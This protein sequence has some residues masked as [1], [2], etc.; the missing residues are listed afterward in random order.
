MPAPR[1]P[2][3]RPRARPCAPDA[4]AREFFR[5]LSSRRKGR[6]AAVWLGPNVA[7]LSFTMVNANR[8]IE[9]KESTSPVTDM[10]MRTQVRISFV[11]ANGNR[12]QWLRLIAGLGSS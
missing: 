11:L 9:E 3:D 4:C 6:L 12:Q 5:S 10:R 1:P 7:A 8:S 2:P